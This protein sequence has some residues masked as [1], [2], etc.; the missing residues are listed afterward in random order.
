MQNRLRLLRGANALLYFGPLLA[1]LGGFGW[2]VVPVFVVI[3]MLWLVILK[4]QEWPRSMAEWSQPE[5]LVALAARGAV[6]LL[7]VLV[8]FGIGRG[9]GGVTGALPNL[10]TMLPI[11]ISFLSIPLARMI[12]DPWTMTRIAA[13]ETVA[14]EAPDADPAARKKDYT[15]A[16]VMVPDADNADCPAPGPVLA[17]A[18]CADSPASSGDTGGDSGSSSAD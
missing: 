3:F 10:P 13:P 7:L 16:P 2:P 5:T 9:L 8:S 6:Q 1:G 14:P 17:D 15:V 12:W 18:L 11:A 4:P